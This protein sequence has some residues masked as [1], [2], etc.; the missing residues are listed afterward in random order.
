MAESRKRTTSGSSG[1]GGKRGGGG[2]SSGR[3]DAFE[4]KTPAELRDA[5]ARN[6][7][8]PL[9]LVMLS[10]ERIQEAVDDA[11]RRGRMTADDA[12]ELVRGL[13][14]RGRRQTNDVLRDLEQMLGRGGGEARRAGSGAADAARGAGDR[15]RRAVG[16]GGSLPIAGYDDLTAAE[17]QKRLGDLSPAELRKLRDYERRNANRKSVLSAIER[18]LS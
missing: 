2:S 9:E 7:I 11:V 18:K 1:R 6:L 14:E 15:V 10:R 17:V 3:D 12:E 16:G 8:R 4:G 5:L 13:L